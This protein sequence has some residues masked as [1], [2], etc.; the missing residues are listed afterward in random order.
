MVSDEERPGRIG[1]TALGHFGQGKQDVLDG[2]SPT[3]GAPNCGRVIFW[4]FAPRKKGQSVVCRAFM[5]LP[6]PLTGFAV[7][8][9]AGSLGWGRANRSSMV[10]M[11]D[12]CLSSTGT[13]AFLTTGVRTNTTSTWWKGLR[14][15]E[16]GVRRVRPCWSLVRGEHSG[17]Q[18]R[19][20][21]TLR[22]HMDSRTLSFLREAGRQVA[23]EPS[24]D[25]AGPPAPPPGL[26]GWWLK[27]WNVH[28]TF[29]EQ[30]PMS[31][32]LGWFRPKAH[33][34]LS[35]TFIGHQVHSIRSH[36]DLGWFHSSHLAVDHGHPKLCNSWL[37]RLLAHRTPKT[38]WDCQDGLPYTLTP[39]APPPQAVSPQSG[40]AVQTCR[41]FGRVHVGRPFCLT[42]ATSR[43]SGPGHWC[44]AHQKL[45][46]AHAA[47]RPAPPVHVSHS[48]PF[49]CMAGFLNWQQA[50]GR[51][52][53]LAAGMRV[54][55]ERRV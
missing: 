32:S 3:A 20:Q 48:E 18:S 31:R 10:A 9:L 44:C 16:T 21:K 22:S 25:G 19:T 53:Y 1:I 13:A 37:K 42:I 14:P 46:C 36:M 28:V 7:L 40:L 55:A 24:L 15:V 47:P 54:G 26:V 2:F 33:Y 29:Q 12:R 5:S 50:A 49:D 8:W 23:L 41:V 38:P 6:L 30:P 11:A 17:S 51:K 27:M 34:K 52:V 43:P 39:L 4:G 35:G 45:G